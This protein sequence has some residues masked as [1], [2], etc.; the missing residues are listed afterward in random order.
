[1]RASV[2]SIGL[3]AIAFVGSNP[4]GRSAVLGESFAEIAGWR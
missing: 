2:S 3:D 1:L 4:L